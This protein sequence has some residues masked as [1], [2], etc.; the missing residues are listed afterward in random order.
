LIIL[1]LNSIHFPSYFLPGFFS[2][3]RFQLLYLLQSLSSLA[4][5]GSRLA[6]HRGTLAPL[7]WL[8][9]GRAAAQLLQRQGL[10]VA[11]GARQQEAMPVALLGGLQWMQ[12]GMSSVAT[13]VGWMGIDGGGLGDEIDD[14]Y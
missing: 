10:G 7:P 11:C 5:L 4:L 9:L 3:L 1:D 8:A 13:E 6:L 12:L 2:H 14:M